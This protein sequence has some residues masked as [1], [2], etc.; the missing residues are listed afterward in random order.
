VIW[1]N[2][3]DALIFTEFDT[4][5]VRSLIEDQLCFWCSMLEVIRITVTVSLI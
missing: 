4:S 3:R 1:V 5:T 2:D